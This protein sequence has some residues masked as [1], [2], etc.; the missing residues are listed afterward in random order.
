MLGGMRRG[1]RLPERA[2]GFDIFILV[3]VATGSIH[4]MHRHGQVPADHRPFMSENF[5]YIPPSCSIAQPEP[6]PELIPVPVFR[7]EVP[8]VDDGPEL[9]GVILQ[10]ITEIILRELQALRAQ[11]VARNS[12]FVTLESAMAMLGCKRSKIFDLLRQGLLKRAQKVGRSV[13]ITVDSIEALLAEG[14]PQ[15]GGKRLSRPSLANTRRRILKCEKRSGSAKQDPGDSIR[16][17]S[18]R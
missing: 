4:T 14:L 1:N 6:P 15:E 5:S 7:S 18:I 13:M 16:K 2:Q 12:T 3:L 8:V 10:G 17:L 9:V 11:D